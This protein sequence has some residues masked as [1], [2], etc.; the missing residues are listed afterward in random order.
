MSLAAIILVVGSL[1]A[2]IALHVV[3]GDL[4][5][6]RRVM[7]E[8][9]NGPAGLVMTAAFYAL[10]LAVLA[11]ALRVRSAIV[12]TRVTRLVPVLLA[13]SGAGF[14]LAGAFEVEPRLRPDTLRE[15]IHSDAAISAFVL[16]I[17]AM[18]LFSLACREDPRWESFRR[19]S[20]S[21][22]L[23]AVVAAAGSPIADRTPWPGLNQRALGLAVVGWLLLT[24]LRIRFRLPADPPLDPG[25]ALIEPVDRWPPQS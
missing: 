6:V 25:A 11:L 9:A 17:V 20:M 10:G 22:T 12:R 19:T 15:Q 2:V 18:L 23:V 21:L 7:S 16:L 14:L 24:A 8:Y 1:G 5:P 3:R 13:L 4:D